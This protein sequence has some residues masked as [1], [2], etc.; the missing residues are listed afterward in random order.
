M[1][2]EG[3]AYC[4]LDYM[5]AVRLS[6]SWP[7]YRF[8]MGQKTVLLDLKP[9]SPEVYSEPG[10]PED[11]FVTDH[12]TSTPLHQEQSITLEL[13]EI[14][15]MSFL[16]R[17]CWCGSFFKVFIEFVTIFLLFYAL[18]FWLRSMWDLSSLNR[19]RT[20]TLCNGEHLWWLRW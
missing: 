16:K 6:Q 3:E 10:Q 17:F 9:L 2:E 8:C 7:L 11:H 19:D 12:I 20:H 13:L 15:Q 4:R 14:P 18:V 1:K 5:L